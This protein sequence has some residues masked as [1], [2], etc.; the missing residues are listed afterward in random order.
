MDTSAFLES[1]RTGNMIK[2][3][4]LLQFES[5]DY[6]V[7]VWN[8]R[9]GIVAR[10]GVTEIGV[11]PDGEM[12]IHTHEDTQSAAQCHRMKVAGI[13]QMMAV[14]TQMAEFLDRVQNGGEDTDNPL[15]GVSV[16]DDARELTVD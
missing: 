12:S 16:P 13:R 8:G 3:V 7:L 9:R 14:A 4:E 6:E 10:F 2:T 15:V 11:T 1:I 5:D